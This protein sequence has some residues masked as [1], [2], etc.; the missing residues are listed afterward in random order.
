MARSRFVGVHPTPATTAEQRG[1]PATRSDTEGSCK[2][3]APRRNPRNSRVE[4]H[5]AEERE[6]FYGES[7]FI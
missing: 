6:Q 3:S 4:S 5:I 7:S 2:R 1:E